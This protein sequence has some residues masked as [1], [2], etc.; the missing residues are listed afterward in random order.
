M[1]AFGYHVATSPADAVATLAGHPGAAYLAGG[2]NLVDHMKLG[3]AE[4]DL[5]VDV[6]RL[7]LDQISVTDDGAVRIGANVRNS[8]LAADPV[9]RSHY[10]V[11]ARALL[12]GASG[13]LRNTAT[14]AGNLLQRTRC[15]YFQDVT[16]PCNKREPGSGCAALGGYARYHAIL[17]ASEHCVAVHPSDMAVAMSALDATVVVQGPDG[18][19]RLPI[20]DFHRLPGDEPQRDTT[21]QHAELITAVELPPPPV[22]AVSDYRKVRDRA[23]YAFALVSVAAELTFTD[24]RQISSA[25]IALGGVAHKPWR[26]RR[27]E[28]VLIGDQPSDET[29]IAAAD[30]ELNAAE[31]L[32]GNEFKVELARRTLV[33]Q[34]RMLTARRQQ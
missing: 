2:T 6:S 10:P 15:V 1:K 22:G 11:L 17:G 26:A 14:T 7:D 33:A 31:P 32:P 30:A 13:Q 20:D 19:R 25:R 4:P 23:S 34:L 3:V 21:L 9:I 12:S 27:A 28:S 16:T 18:Q 24:T 5:L 29:F 8:D